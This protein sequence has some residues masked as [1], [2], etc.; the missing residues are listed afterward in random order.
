MGSGTKETESLSPS[1]GPHSP[2]YAKI[3]EP[4]L[5]FSVLVSSSM[6]LEFLCGR[7][8]SPTD[9]SSPHAPTFFHGLGEQ[10]NPMGLSNYAAMHLLSWD[11][12]EVFSA[13]PI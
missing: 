6:A 4:F 10:R 5:G 3:V 2:N 13:P 1:P 7:L 9:H 11:E 8:V 12:I